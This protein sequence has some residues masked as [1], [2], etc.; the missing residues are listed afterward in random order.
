MSTVSSNCC[1]SGLELSGLIIFYKM[2][3]N[4]GEFITLSFHT[5]QMTP[6]L[7]MRISKPPCVCSRYAL[8]LA[9]LTL[10]VI[11]SWKGLQLVILNFNSSSWTAFLADS[12]FLAVYINSFKR[13]FAMR[14]N[15]CIQTGEINKPIEFF[16]QV[17]SDRKTDSSIAAC[18]NS[19]LLVFALRIIC[20]AI[21][22]M[23]I[24][25]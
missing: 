19:N 11:S 24:L 4:G 8:I 13:T 10:S 6:A 15:I 23:F 2:K 20:H 9:T 25:K 1:L 18:D 5:V 22:T 16:R 14:F 7:L 12:S 21:Q 3:K 17:F